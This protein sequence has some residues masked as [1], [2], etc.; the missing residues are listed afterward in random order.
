M[1]ADATYF[2]ADTARQGRVTL[3]LG[4]STAIPADR[5]SFD[6]ALALNTIYFW[7]NPIADLQELRRV[8]R[9]DG[10]LVLGALA[11]WSA[12]GRPVF[13]HGFR[14]YEQPEIKDLL[15]LQTSPR[16]LSIKSTRLLCRQWVSPGIEITSSSL[17]IVPVGRCEALLLFA[18]VCTRHIAL[19]GPETY[20]SHSGA[21]ASLRGR[22]YEFTG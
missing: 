7:P 8:L 13:Q 22:M 21:Y 15:S 4:T 6:Q 19:P 14:F 11:P 12:V 1:A 5:H 9:S 17:R 10:R 3:A 2:N 20:R 18:R 16:Y